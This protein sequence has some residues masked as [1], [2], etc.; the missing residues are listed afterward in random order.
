MDTD[1]FIPCGTENSWEFVLKFAKSS[2]VVVKE[3]IE[4]KSFK[5]KLW[6][7][8]L[9][10]K[11]M[12]LTPPALNEISRALKASNGYLQYPILDRELFTY[13][14]LEG[15]STRTTAETT[16]RAYPLRV[17]IFMSK[18]IP[19]F[20]FLP[21]IYH[22]IQMTPMWTRSRPSLRTDFKAGV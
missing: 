16:L 22:P 11:K 5:Y 20:T 8:R 2:F 14:L 9:H 7:A 19:A 18:G 21:G 13:S 10:L 15:V 12:K 17:Y 1:K 3:S 6:G 4:T